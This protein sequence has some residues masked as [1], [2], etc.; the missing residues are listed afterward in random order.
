MFVCV[1]RAAGLDLLSVSWQS[2]CG[3]FLA[4]S[5]NPLEHNLCC[6]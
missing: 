2:L 4:R 5:Y 6:V 1:F 3:L